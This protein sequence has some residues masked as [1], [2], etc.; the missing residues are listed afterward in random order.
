MYEYVLGATIGY[1]SSMSYQVSM[2]AAS[3]HPFTGALL[4]L[5]AR[6]EK[7]RLSGRV[8][9]EMRARLRIDPELAGVKTPEE[10]AELLDVRR[11]Y[12]LLDE[13]GHDVFQRV[14]YEPW[15]EVSP[16]DPASGAWTVQVKQGPA[17]VGFQVQAQPGPWLAAGSSY[18]AKGALL[19]ESFDDLAPYAGKA[20]GQAS[21]THLANGEGG[22][23]LAGVTQ[24]LDVSEEDVREGAHCGVYTAESALNT[25][26]GWS[27]VT[28]VFDSPIDL[29][30]HKA[31]GFWL[32]GD[33]HGGL[34]KL[35]LTDGAKAADYYVANDY[36]GWRYQQ[37][38]RPQTDPMDYGQ[39]RTL[40][41]YYNGLPA[42]TTVSCAIDDVKALPALDSRTL[43][44]PWVEI[45][46]TRLAWRGALREGQYAF[47]WPGE[48][49]LRY[50]LPLTDAEHGGE[51]APSFT[52]PEGAHAVRFGC[53]APLLSPV[54]VRVTLQPPERYVMP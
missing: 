34:F 27:V 52:L 53:A 51:A 9:D 10:R 26:G 19:L 2:D 17:R 45:D 40:S 8:P 41:F 48:A 33:E 38:A 28:K 42:K 14:V 12:R 30:W 13:D 22:G 7:L 46:G 31:I 54:R 49:P 23:T 18:S 24:H 25:D 21:V 3:R 1:D 36:A 37:L 16:A 35:Q 11:D 43:G 39:V 32:R 6:Y 29:S 4:D 20:A 44:D 15:R 50:G 5:I 47:V